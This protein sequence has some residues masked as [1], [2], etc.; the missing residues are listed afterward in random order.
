MVSEMI[1]VSSDDKRCVSIGSSSVFHSL[2][3]TVLVRLTKNLDQYPLAIGF[4]EEKVCEPQNGI[5]T[6]RQFNLIRDALAKFPPEKAVYDYKDKKRKAPWVDN[7]SPVVTSC[8]NL[9]TTEDGKDLL[10]EIVSILTYAAYSGSTI[11]IEEG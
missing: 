7:V 11:R 4:F 5:Q 8:A 10:F 9:Y 1:I 3:S 6:A 2:Y